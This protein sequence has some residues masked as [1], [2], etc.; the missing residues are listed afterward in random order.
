MTGIDVWCG[1]ARLSVWSSLSFDVL[2][3]LVWEERDWSDKC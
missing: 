3:L 1:L 2:L